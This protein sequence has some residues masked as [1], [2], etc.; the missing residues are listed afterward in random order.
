M[1]SETKIFVCYCLSEWVKIKIELS[2]TCYSFNCQLLHTPAGMSEL[3]I[4]GNKDTRRNNTLYMENRN[5]I[6]KQQQ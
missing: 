6:V 2:D 4:N 5:Y 1:Q 3:P